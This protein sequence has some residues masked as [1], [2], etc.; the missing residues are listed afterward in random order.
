MFSN[1]FVTY[2]F[3]EPVCVWILQRVVKFNDSLLILLT[4]D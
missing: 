4:I 1:S 2:Y 3:L